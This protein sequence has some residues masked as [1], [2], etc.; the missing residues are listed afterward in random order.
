MVE[1]RKDIQ[2]LRGVSLLFVFLYRY[3]KSL[4][5][6]GF[7]GVDIFLY[8]SGYVN[9][10]SYIS[11]ESNSSL[12]FFSNRIKRIVPVSHLTLF[13]SILIIAKMNIL[14][15]N[16]QLTDIIY[17]MLSLSNYRFIYLSVDY[18]SQ[19]ESPSIVLHYWSL[20]IEDQ[21]YLFFPYYITLIYKNLICLI[22]ITLLFFFYGCLININH[23]CISYF[24]SLSRSYQFLF[25]IL[26][27]KY[28]IANN[29][30]LFIKND[31]LIL[32]LL[33]Y[34]ILI[35]DDRYFPSPLSIIPLIIVYF[36]ITRRSNILILNN[37][38][39]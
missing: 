24:S 32:M 39:C 1:F 16:K 18:L 38:Y 7:I 28:K 27:T 29:N 33:L 5:P 4:L 30:L 26:S 11:K 35:K 37:I 34:C 10:L 36:I 12:T 22:I 6:T 20:A 9:I 8:I 17:A 2:C 19:N 14:Y 31:I 23:H 15:Q 21:F 25:G 13:V 3:N